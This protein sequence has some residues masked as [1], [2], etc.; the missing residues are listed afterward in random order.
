MGSDDKVATQENVC[1][2]SD[3]YIVTIKILSNV[4]SLID[5]SIQLYVPQTYQGSYLA[6]KTLDRLL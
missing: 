2:T 1:Y 6:L 4:R 3:G 5:P